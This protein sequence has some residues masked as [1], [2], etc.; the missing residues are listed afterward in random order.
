MVL[1]HLPQ[2]LQSKKLPLQVEMFIIPHNMK[3]LEAKNN[4]LYL[5]MYKIVI[6]FNLKVKK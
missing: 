1:I 2:D 3:V 5:L 6:F 4:I